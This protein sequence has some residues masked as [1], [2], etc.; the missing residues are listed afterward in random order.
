MSFF[1]DLGKKVSR[2]T[3]TVTQKGKE[4]AEITK[5]NFSVSEEEKKIDDNYTKIG[6]LFVQKIGDRSEGEFLP[7][8]NEIKAS[9]EKIS[10][11][12]AQINAIRGTAI[13]EKCGA[14][15]T[16][17]AVFCTGCGA[18]VKPDENVEAKDEA[19]DNEETKEQ[20]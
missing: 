12:K 14:A 1:D 9:E 10:Q 16:D 17:E 5:L 19:K 18:K 6:K 8:V 15:L 20:Q 4:L 7:L 2:A 13:C 3:Q 11:L